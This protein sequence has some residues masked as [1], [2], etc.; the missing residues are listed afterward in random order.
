MY[1]CLQRLYEEGARTFWIHNMGP[2][3]CLPAAALYIRNPKPGFLDH[4]GCI[5][6]QNAMAARFNALL[7][8]RVT[9]L[10]VELP[11]ASLVYVDVYSAKYHL[12]TNATYYGMGSLVSDR[13]NLF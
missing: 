11:R 3:G 13:L 9:K 8:A 6:N 12:I 2:I 5:K 10:R 4:N 7:K 1:K